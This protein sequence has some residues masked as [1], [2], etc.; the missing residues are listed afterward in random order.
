MYQ[1]MRT[2]ETTFPY[3]TSPGVARHQCNECGK[4]ERADQ[5]T[6]R[7]SKSC[8]SKAQA[9]AV[10]VAMPRSVSRAQVYAAR[11]GGVSQSGLSE[12]QIVE[13]VKYGFISGDD[14]MNRDY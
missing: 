3:A 9:V 11:Q 2:I 10:P 4:W 6:I 8:E 14:A 5:G 7:H 1:G 13:A 12:D